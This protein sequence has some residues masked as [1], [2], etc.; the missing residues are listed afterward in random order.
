MGSDPDRDL[1]DDA[2]KVRVAVGQ[3][4]FNNTG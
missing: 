4:T 3:V 1:Y 2:S